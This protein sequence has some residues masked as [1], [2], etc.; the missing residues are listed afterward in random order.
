[1]NNQ[2]KHSG[3]AVDAPNWFMTMWDR[4]INNRNKLRLRGMISLE[5]LTEG[6]DGY[7]LLFQTGESLKGKPLI[8]HQ[9]PH[10]FFMELSTTWFYRMSYNNTFFAYVSLP[11][12][13]AL[14]PT[15]YM[16][17]PSADMNPDA[18][19]AHHWQ[20]ATHIT[21]GVF[22]VGLIAQKFKVDASVFTGKEPDENR[23]NFDV[24]RFNSYSCR[25][26]YRF[27]SEF[28]SQI[29]SGFLRSPEW[30]H[31]EINQV[32]ITGSLETAFAIKETG[33]L[34][35]SFVYGGNIEIEHGTSNL[36]NAFLLEF[37]LE[38][39]RLVPYGRYELVQKKGEDLG[40]TYANQVK[41]NIQGITLG[42]AVKIFDLLSLSFFAGVQTTMN[43]S[44]NSLHTEYGSLPFSYELYVRLRPQKLAMADNM[45]GMTNNTQLE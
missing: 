13:P 23:W 32:R 1:V 8:D 14:G 11:G 7:P 33:T 18:P 16:H 38:L 41:F 35:G 19:L 39:N 5:P 40:I 10:D 43:I 36:V 20:D 29:S 17:R 2:Q 6:N 42:T 15:T 12:E 28:E 3:N 26:S 27:T 30:L 45:P 37:E 4:T 25:L 44:T 9:H 24:P 22:T 21:F 31:P 34:S